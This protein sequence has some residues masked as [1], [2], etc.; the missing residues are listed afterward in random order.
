[1]VLRR[2]ELEERKDRILAVTIDHYIKTVTPVGSSYVAKTCALDLSSATIRNILAELEQEG[3]LTHPHT[4]AGRVPTELGYRYYVDNLMN[5]IQ[6]LQEERERIKAEYTQASVELEQLLDK[7]SEVIAQTT[8]YTSIISVDGWG[9]K[10]FCK[11]TSFVVEYPE[12]QDIAKIRGI[13]LALDQKESLLEIINRDLEKKMNI[14]IGHEMAL[15]EIDH[16]SLVVTP[17]KTK[18]GASGRIAVLGPT[19]MDYGRVIS[20]LGYFTNLM[21]EIE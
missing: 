15:R 2:E 13:L 12:Y 16:C 3:F 10:I 1:M 4:S 21:E 7:T 17:Y 18:D 6:M 5:E 20:T 9:S 19:R 11:G 14:Y 8:Q